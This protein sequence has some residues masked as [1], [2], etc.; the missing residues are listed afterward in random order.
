MVTGI[1]QFGLLPCKTM[2]APDAIPNGQSFLKQ[3]KPYHTLRAFP[4]YFSDLNK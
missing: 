4:T 3:Q 2:L 1:L